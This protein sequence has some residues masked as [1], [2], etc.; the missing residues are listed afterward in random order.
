MK[1]SAW[2]QRLAA[3]IGD[4]APTEKPSYVAYQTARPMKLDGD[5]GDWWLGEDKPAI[6][7]AI[8]LLD[9]QRLADVRAV[10]DERSL[11]LSYSVQAPNGPLNAGS[12]LP[13]SPFVSGA[14]VDFS[15]APRISPMRP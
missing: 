12:E 8:V 11:Y 15:I 13:L 2:R 6:P 5:L 3:F 14:Y 10:Y 7:T 9:G 1:K 4:T